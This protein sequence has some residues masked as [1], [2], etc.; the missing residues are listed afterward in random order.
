MENAARTIDDPR[1]QHFCDPKKRTGTIIAQSLGEPSRLAWDIYLFYP[2]GSEWG[3]ALPQ[4]TA[5]VHQVSDMWADH[6]R[7]GDDLSRE[8][9]GIAEH[10]IRA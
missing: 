2:A 7:Y 1:V 8:L 5:W 10:L 6:Y 4:P 3:N 9:H